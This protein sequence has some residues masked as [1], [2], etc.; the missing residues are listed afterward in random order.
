MS[1]GLRYKALAGWG[2]LWR[3]I[4]LMLLTATILAN[5]ASAEVYFDYL[6]GSDLGMGIGARA[7]SMGGAFF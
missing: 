1:A 2:S 6:H 3:A 7:V 4:T 5:I